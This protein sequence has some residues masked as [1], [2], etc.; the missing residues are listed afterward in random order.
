MRVIRAASGMQLA[1]LPLM[2]KIKELNTESN[3]I[4]EGVK[5]AIIIADGFEA[6]EFE[7]PCETL[8]NA[9]AQIDVLVMEPEQVQHGAQGMKHLEQDVCVKGDKLLHG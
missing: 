4:L 9:G 1:I 3:R 5:I 7:V 6:S 8:Q 2:D